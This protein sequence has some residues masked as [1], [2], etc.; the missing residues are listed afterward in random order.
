MSAVTTHRAKIR[1]SLK[2]ESV[3]AATVE[4]VGII[5][6]SGQILLRTGQAFFADNVARL[7]AALAFY[8]TVA[9]APLLVLTIAVAGTVFATGDARQRK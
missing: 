2:G 3:I 9:V 7:C 6:R 8:T 5:T 4:Q 1:P